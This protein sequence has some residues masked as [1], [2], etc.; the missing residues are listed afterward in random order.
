MNY[1]NLSKVINKLSSRIKY[2]QDYIQDRLARGETEIMTNQSK[3][4]AQTIAWTMMGGTFIAIGWLATAKTEEVV[5]ATGKLEPISG[6]VD[7]QMP[8]KA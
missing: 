3:V 4:W 7:V 8:Y 6:V 5:I 1:Q 2:S